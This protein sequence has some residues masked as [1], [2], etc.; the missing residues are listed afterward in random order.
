MCAK[1]ILQS[2]IQKLEIFQE[3]IVSSKDGSLH[4]DLEEPH[5]QNS[6]DMLYI[7]MVSDKEWDTDLESEG[8]NS[9]RFVLLCNYNF[10]CC[11]M[12]AIRLLNAR[13]VNHIFVE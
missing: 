10:C 7:D 2:I 4:C 12:S 6:V 11:C 1:H 8:V 5:Q 13:I 9:F 3:R